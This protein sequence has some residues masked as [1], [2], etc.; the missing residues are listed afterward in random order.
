MDIYS[1]QS[2]WK[3]WLSF[4]AI[5]IVIASLFYTNGVANRLADAERERADLWGRA[6]VELGKMPEDPDCVGIDPN[7]IEFNTDFILSIIES[8]KTIPVILT[9]ERRNIQS[10]VNLNEEKAEEDTS[11]LSKQLGIMMAQNEPI[12]VDN[13]FDKLFL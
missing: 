7:C 5:L 10:H 4:G 9:D 2:R 11:Y 3:V 12:I 8:N 6:I 1:K 13:G